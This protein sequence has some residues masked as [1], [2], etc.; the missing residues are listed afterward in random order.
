M[1]ILRYESNID[2]LAQ[3]KLY[4]YVNRKFIYTKYLKRAHD[5]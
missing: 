5:E 1:K 2:S 4:D 3:G